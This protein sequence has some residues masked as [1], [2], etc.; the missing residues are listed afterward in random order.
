MTFV[1][2]HNKNLECDLF[3]R[4]DEYWLQMYVERKEP[5]PRS[6][7]ACGADV[8]MANP[9]KCSKLKSFVCGHQQQKVR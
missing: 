8:C 9:D 4:C 2:P 7:M 6:Q 1:C 3:Y 5:V